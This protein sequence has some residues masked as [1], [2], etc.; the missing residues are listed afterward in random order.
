MPCHY[1][2]EP[3]AV[4]KLVA[5]G[6]H[7]VDVFAN[8]NCSQNNSRTQAATLTFAY[9]YASFKRVCYVLWL[10]LQARVSHIFLALWFVATSLSFNS[11]QFA[12]STAAEI[13]SY[14]DEQISRTVPWKLLPQVFRK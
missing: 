4:L 3:Y 7:N 11:L 6:S 14:L 9:L 12:V 13:L 10:I 5:C 1:S 2:A 8:G